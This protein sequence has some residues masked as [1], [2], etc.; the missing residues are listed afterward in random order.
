MAKLPHRSASPATEST[1]RIIGGLHRGRKLPIPELSGLRPTADRTR[2]TLFNWLQFDIVD[3]TVLD[4][5]AGT[6]ALGLEA[7]SRGAQSA[8]FVEP[9]ARAAE[10]IVRSL[11]TLALP[12]GSVQRMMAQQFLTTTE[13]RFDLIFV[14]PPFSADLWSVTLEGLLAANILTERGYIYLECPQSQAIDIPAPWAT[15][16]DKTAGNV[17]IRLLAGH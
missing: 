5:F 14:D 3:M 11:E 2:E 8:I 17:R 9:Q 4:L 15:V 12:Q 16:K 10:G 13:Q 1:L 7:L 6:G